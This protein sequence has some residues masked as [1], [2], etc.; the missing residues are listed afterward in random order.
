MEPVLYTI[1]ERTA[2]IT[3]NRPEKRNALNREVVENLKKYFALAEE[4][5]MVKTI[6]FKGSGNAFCSG[7]D[8]KYI[9]ELQS[10]SDS[11]NLEDSNE[12][13]DLFL[14]I[15]QTSKPVIAQINGPALAG[16][17]GLVSVCDFAFCTSESK[18]GYTEVRIGF[19]PA[20]V[21]VFL[22]RKIGES[23]S[24]RFLLSGE[25]F[26][27]ETAKKSGLVNDYFEDEEDLET[28]VY[29]FTAKLNTQNSSTA[30]AMTKSLLIKVQ[31]LSLKEALSEAVKA[32]ASARKT[33]DC[34][35]GINAFL[36]KEKPK[37]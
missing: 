22:I 16:G 36:N 11:E 32:N 6:V 8:L 9:Q 31:D 24:R 28:F 4:D 34:K 17:C 23:K 5:E 14:K 18:F 33:D 13:K 29:E 35:K 10:F 27:C 19:I 1:K 3:I 37:W 30:M 21:M 26:D 2:Y 15:Y 7:A 12:L 20:I 25:I